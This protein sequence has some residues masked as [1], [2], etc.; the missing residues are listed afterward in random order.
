[1]MVKAMSANLDQQT[2]SGMK[3]LFNM[4]FYVASKGLAFKNFP[5]LLDLQG[6]NGLDIGIQYH[7]DKE[8]KK[9][10]SSTALV[11]QQRMSEKV[12]N[13]RFLCVPADR[14]TDKSTTE[15]RAVY[16]RYTGPNGR[17]TRVRSLLTLLPYNHQIQL[18]LLKELKKG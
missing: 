12:H 1:M 11:E 14:S 10:V 7:T 15:Q 8:C 5:G 17:P 6:Y 3:I 2:Q 4:A 13:A 9:L 16:V 18:V